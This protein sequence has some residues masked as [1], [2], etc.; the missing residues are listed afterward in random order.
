ML[1]QQ[2]SRLIPKLRPLPQCNKCW[3]H[4]LETTPFLGNWRTLLISVFRGKP[5]PLECC[6]FC[7]SCV[8]SF[9]G[10]LAYILCVQSCCLA[11]QKL[12]N[13]KGG[14]LGTRLQAAFLYFPV[15]QM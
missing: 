10:S 2:G 7:T 12:C 15:D 11:W 1:N 4:F 9:S 6:V 8:A 14:R 13:S 5:I 3:T